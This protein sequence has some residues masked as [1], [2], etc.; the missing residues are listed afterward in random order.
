MPGTP[1]CLHCGNPIPAGTRSGDDSPPS[2]CCPGCAQVHALIERAG[3]GR[4]YDLRDRP[5]VPAVIRL[6]SDPE[7]RWLEDAEAELAAGAGAADGAPREA[8]EPGGIVTRHYR[9]QGIACA[10]C[11]WLI[12]QV[13]ERHPGGAGF[14]LNPVMGTLSLRFDPATFPLRRFLLDL[15]G[16][17]YALTPG[18]AAPPAR[19][20]ALLLRLGLA[21][22]IA[23]NSMVLAFAFYFGLGPEEPV[24][25]R[26]FLGYNLALGTL[27]VVLCGSHF[28]AHAAAALRRR[29]FTLD[30]SIALGILLTYAASLHQHFLGDPRYTYFDSLAAFI[31]FML[32]GRWL[33]EHHIERNRH[34][35]LSEDPLG[36]ARVQ[37][38]RAGALASI[39]PSAV[40]RGD[41]LLLH[42]GD[43]VPAA[44]VLLAPSA[45]F[46]LDW[47][48]GEGEPVVLREGGIVPAGAIVA[49]HTATTVRADEGFAEGRLAELFAERIEVRQSAKL[50]DGYG[51]L[52]R[53]YLAGTLLVC[54]V[55]AGWWAAREEPATALRVLATLLM[56]TC[57]CAIGI[58]LP[59]AFELTVGRLRAA[60]VYLRNALALFD[61]LAIRHVL[62][63]KTGTLTLTRPRLDGD[64]ALAALDPVDRDVVFNMASRSFHPVSRAIAVVLSETGAAFEAGFEKQGVLREIPGVGLEW[65]SGGRTWRIRRQGRDDS[66]SPMPPVGRDG[67]GR[68]VIERDGMT[69]ALLAPREGYK[70]DAAAE[71]AGL[72]RSGLSLGILSGDARARVERAAEALGIPRAAARGELTP[73]MKEEAVR[74]YPPGTVLMVGDGLNDLAAFRA[75][76]VRA[77]PVTDRPFLVQEA[78]VAFAG[79]G[80]HGVRRFLEEARR[81]ARIERG[82]VALALAYNAVVIG[83]AVADRLDPYAV[84]V[85]MPANSIAFIAGVT[86]VTRRGGRPE[87]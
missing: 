14:E 25:Y 11:A 43:L 77:A 71:I 75:A 78:D 63:D 56:V 42:R 37:V 28:F 29:I 2:F 62:F 73:R 46:R 8:A 39:P 41:D 44:S 5:L 64:V 86:W 53:W 23:M 60:G 27:S 61:A 48:T 54:A 20:S 36:G 67:D 55:G 34:A 4:F 68:T 66:G 12:E 81:F 38:H 80:V 50:V 74:A 84:A 33:A 15:H 58:S 76:H 22:A 32:L 85:L 83:F 19:S 17:G 40:R 6:E 10:A 13:F 30:Y 16:F 65:S 72:A 49:Q 3:L 87:A 47:L 18:S 79:E 35:L 69:L 70:T 9:I 52:T 57:P 26:F 24:L 7:L 59:L 51:R 45:E 82:T 1:A 31:F 21:G